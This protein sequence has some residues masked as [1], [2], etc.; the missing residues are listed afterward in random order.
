MHHLKSIRERLGVTQKAL[1]EGIGCTQ[2]NIVHL[3]RGQV[4]MPD[5]AARLIR[6]AAGGGL[7]IGFDHVYGNAELPQLAVGA[8]SGRG[9]S[10]A[11]SPQA[12]QGA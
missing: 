4:L 2:S 8:E 3:E 9:Q 6:F 11:P 1:A 10:R 5:V 12:E 7:L